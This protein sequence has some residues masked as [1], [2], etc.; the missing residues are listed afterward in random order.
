MAAYWKTHRLKGH[1][2]LIFVGY[3][4]IKIEVL[5]D[6]KFTKNKDLT[7]KRAVWAGAWDKTLTIIPQSYRG[8]FDKRTHRMYRIFSHTFNGFFGQ[9]S[10]PQSYKAQGR[11]WRWENLFEKI[12]FTSFSLITYTISRPLHDQ[13]PRLHEIKNRKG[14]KF[15]D[16]RPVVVPFS[17][18]V[19]GKLHASFFE[20][21][22][23]DL[24]RV[25][26]PKDNRNE[27][28]CSL[29]CPPPRPNQKL[30]VTATRR[31]A[32]SSRLHIRVTIWP[33][34]LKAGWR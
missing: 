12:I 13:W 7:Q 17:S 11:S 9:L 20:N 5:R 4:S 2:K 16:N 24:G 10:F 14:S 22:E 6:F 23:R 26:N 34:L 27:L 19:I 28:R 31:I 3:F 18:R 8:T 1:E 33:G 25:A 29:H 30:Q 32:N 21:A 15:Q